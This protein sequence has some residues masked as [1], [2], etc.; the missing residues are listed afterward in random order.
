MQK[1]ICGQRA[2]TTM[3]KVTKCSSDSS[4]GAFA[5]NARK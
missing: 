1:A 4:A 3:A 2:A 5:P